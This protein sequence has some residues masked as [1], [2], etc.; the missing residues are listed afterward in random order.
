[1]TEGNNKKEEILVFIDSLPDLVRIGQIDVVKDFLRKR[2]E[3]TLSDR[4]A[5]YGMLPSL[6][7]RLE[8]FNSLVQEMRDLYVNEYHRG[9][10]ALC[11]MSVEA[12]C[13]TIAEERVTDEKLKQELIDPSREIR[14]KIE[15]LRKYFRIQKTASLLHRVLD[16]RKEYIHLHRTKILLQEVLECIK[17]THLAIVF[18]YGLLP[19][20]AGKARFVT[21][22]DVENLEK[23]IGLT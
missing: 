20:E 4:I 7:V 15:S 2:F 16:I 8:P 1:M 19:T 18:E 13:I 12:L 6:L 14:K 3:Q 17:K 21:Q 11:G 23:L 9:A 22:E 10:I 5:R